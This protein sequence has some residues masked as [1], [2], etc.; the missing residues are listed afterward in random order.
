LF[1]LVGVVG[2][3]FFL[4]VLF[5]GVGWGFSCPIGQPGP[6][7]PHH[8][9]FA[10]FPPSTG[11]FFSSKTD[12]FFC[13]LGHPKSPFFPPHHAGEAPDFLYFF[14]LPRPLRFVTFPLEILDHSLPAGFFQFRFDTFRHH[15]S[16]TLFILTI[17]AF[18]LSPPS[19]LP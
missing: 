3:F 4:G 9:L 19:C 7:S 8:N 18:P 16:P 15:W 2:G 1:F 14:C 13:F 10:L 6:S 17:F 11:C 12:G 5:G